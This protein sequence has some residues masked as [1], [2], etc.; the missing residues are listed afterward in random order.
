M[1]GMV[2]FM[3]TIPH[4]SESIPVARRE[5][6]VAPPVVHPVRAGLAVGIVLGGSHVLWSFLVA[7]GWAQPLMD[8]LFRINFVEPSYTVTSFAAGTAVMLVV[9]T[10]A[11]GFAMG[12]TVA[13]VWNRLP[14]PRRAA[15]RFSPPNR[16]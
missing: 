16:P 2:S 12:W 7:V 3:S 8:F 4:P 5:A 6:T 14:Q 13:R 10:A 15:E 9:V 11:V 1:H